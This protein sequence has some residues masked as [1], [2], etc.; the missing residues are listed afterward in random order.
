MCHKMAAERGVAH[1]QL[2]I[3]QYLELKS[4]RVLT[5]NHG[6]LVAT[7]GERMGAHVM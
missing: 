5:I 2:P 6:R 1:A 7:N 3:G 4:R